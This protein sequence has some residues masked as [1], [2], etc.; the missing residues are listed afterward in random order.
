MRATSYAC[1][2]VVIIRGMLFAKDSSERW[3][4]FCVDSN[5]NVILEAQGCTSDMK[6]LVS[7]RHAFFTSLF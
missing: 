2:S 1:L 3:L 4:N 5:T 6:A 7:E